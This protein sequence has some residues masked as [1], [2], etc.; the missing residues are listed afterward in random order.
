MWAARTRFLDMKA[1]YDDLDEDTRARI[2]GLVAV[3]LLR[4]DGWT[5]R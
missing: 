2:D 1:A 4:V 3:S 5:R